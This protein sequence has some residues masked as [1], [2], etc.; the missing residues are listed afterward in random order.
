MRKLLL[1]ST[2]IFLGS[3]PAYAGGGGT[4]CGHYSGHATI[5]GKIGN[6]R[7][8]GETS[9]FL[10]LACEENRLLFGDIRYKA[11]DRDNRE[12]NIGAGVRFL[13]E[14]GI[15]GGYIFFDRRRSG[16]TEKLHSQITAGAEW[17]AENWEVRSNVYAPLTEEKQ[18]GYGGG[19]ATGSPF[20]AGSGIFVNV[21]G[22][23][24]ITEKPLWGVDAE[25]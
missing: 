15:A 12:G 11:D 25:A 20:L 21:A 23:Q 17:L 18:A 13:K 7:D 8:I 22:Q 19:T 16:A 1:L 3:G 14:S 4:P 10:P 6:D 9:L 24:I 2:A 5:E